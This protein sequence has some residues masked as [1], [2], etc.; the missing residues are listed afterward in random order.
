MRRFVRT[1]FI[2]RHAQITVLED[3][4]ARAFIVY[5]WRSGDETV[6]Q[7]ATFPYE[8]GMSPEIRPA[9]IAAAKRAVEEETEGR[10]GLRKVCAWCPGFDALAPENRNATHTICPSCQARLFDEVKT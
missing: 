8:P 5:R 7:L 9:A 2:K 3:S 1:F 6:T 10:E 4:A